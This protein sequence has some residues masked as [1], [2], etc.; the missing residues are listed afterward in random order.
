VNIVEYIII[1]DS[2]EAEVSRVNFAPSPPKEFR[3][4]P[5]RSSTP[6]SQ[7]YLRSYSG[8]TSKKLSRM[9]RSEEREILVTP[10]VSG[11][12]YTAKLF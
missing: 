7:S 3:I 10:R 2:G 11:L 1:I 6:D 12:L 5:D 4:T 9:S 8:T